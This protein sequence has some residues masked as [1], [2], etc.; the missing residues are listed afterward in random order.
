M[1]MATRHRDNVLV[2]NR[3]GQGKRTCPRILWMFKECPVDEFWVGI[4][5]TE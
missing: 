3:V 1:D 5:G 2:G 4:G